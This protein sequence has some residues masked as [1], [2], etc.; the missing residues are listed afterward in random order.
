MT[1]KYKGFRIFRYFPIEK[2]KGGGYA[3]RHSHLNINEEGL[4]IFFGPNTLR[5]KSEGEGDASRYGHLMHVDI[6]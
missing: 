5:K 4:M 1:I 6:K 3:S 2:N